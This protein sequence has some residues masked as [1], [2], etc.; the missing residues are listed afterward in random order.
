MWRRNH[1]TIDGLKKHPT[2]FNPH[3]PSSIAYRPLSRAVLESFLAQRGMLHK[4]VEWDD[5]FHAGLLNKMYLRMNDIVFHGT[6][7]ADIIHVGENTTEHDMEEIDA[8]TQARP[9]TLGTGNGTDEDDVSIRARPLFRWEGMFDD[10]LRGHQPRHRRWL[11]KLGVWFGLTSR[12]RAGVPSAGLA[13]DVRLDNGQYVLLQDDSDATSESN[14]AQV[15][16]ESQEK[17]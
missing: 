10:R 6:D 17:E 13:L 4:K 11:A 15:P 9:S 2:D 12:W 1:D 5:A 16:H 7:R 3:Y 14:E 8:E